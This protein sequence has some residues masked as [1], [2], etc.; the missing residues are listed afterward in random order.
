MGPLSRG[1]IAGR[2]KSPEL[3]FALWERDGECRF[4][5]RDRVDGGRQSILA[6]GARALAPGMSIKY[7]RHESGKNRDI[8]G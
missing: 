5:A 6:S 8:S 1:Y 2:S 7:G 3:A 4:E